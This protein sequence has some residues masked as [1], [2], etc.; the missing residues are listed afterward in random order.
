MPPNF[1]LPLSPLL[2]TPAPPQVFRFCVS[3]LPS[4]EHKYHHRGSQALLVIILDCVDESSQRIEQKGVEGKILYLNFI[5]A[6][7]SIAYCL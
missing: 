1:P 3:F 6:F 5:V 4:G 7:L 2:P